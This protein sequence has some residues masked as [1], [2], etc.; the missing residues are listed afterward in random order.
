MRPRDKRLSGDDALRSSARILLCLIFV[1]TTASTQ[2]APILSAQSGPT[3]GQTLS[4]ERLS[5]EQAVRT[6]LAQ[7]L[8]FRAELER[9][10]V[11]EGQ[12]RQAGLIPNPFLTS[13]GATDRF[14]ANEGET[15]WSAGIQQ[16]LETAGKR[17]Y[18]SLTARSDLDRVRHETESTQRDLIA[19]TQKAYFTLVFAE[20]DLNLARETSAILRRF[21]DLNAERVKVGEAPGVELNLSKIELARS[22]RNEQEFERRYRGAMA[23]LNLLMGRP[24]AVSVIATSDFAAPLSLPPDDELLDYGLQHRPEVLAADS[25]VEAR[26]NAVRLA[27]ALRFPN[28][29]LGAGYQQQNSIIGGSSAAGQASQ[30]LRRNEQLAFQATL[31]LPLFNRNQGNVASADYERRAAEETARYVRNVVENEI[32]IALANYRS[33]VLTRTLYEESVLP[34]LQRNIDAIQ[35]SYRLGNENIFAVI[36]V[37]RTFFDA[38]HEYIQTLLDLELDRIDLENATGRPLR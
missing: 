25:N 28:L 22:Q 34:Q 13:T 27:R 15:G 37:Q 1:A 3:S 9:I 5:V 30:I 2:S 7:N 31:P 6:A 12:L 10:P 33:R 8:A 36:Q 16:E 21:V 35:E 17:H 24:P 4:G 29:T 32:S 26:T 14:Y 18:R 11:A 19:R 20:R 23:S 38:R